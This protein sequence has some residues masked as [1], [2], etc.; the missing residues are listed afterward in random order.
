MNGDRHIT[1]VISGEE[2]V[3]CGDESDLIVL[4]RLHL[5]NEHDR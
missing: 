4:V 3:Q 5:E 1:P 2:Q